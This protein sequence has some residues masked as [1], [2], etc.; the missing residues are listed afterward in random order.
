M[1]VSCVVHVF[2][3]E[4]QMEMCVGEGG[5][6]RKEKKVFSCLERIYREMVWMAKKYLRLRRASKGGKWQSS[7]T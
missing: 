5:D 2:L 4:F 7:W 6:S 3:I 1:F